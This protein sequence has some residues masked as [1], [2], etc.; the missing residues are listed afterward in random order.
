MSDD[1]EDDASDFDGDIQ[2]LVEARDIL[3]AGLT[4]TDMAKLFRVSSVTM[5]SVIGAIQPSGR[6]GTRPIY[7]VA[8]AAPLVV[9]PILDV[10]SYIRKLKPKDLPPSLQK[11]FWDAQEARQ[12]FE[13]KAGNLWH[14]YRVQEVIGKLVM[15]VR[16]RLVLATDQVD[17][18][19]PLTEEQRK[20]VQGTF[21]AITVELQKQVV[22]AF[23]DYDGAGDRQDLFENGPPKPFRPADSPDDGLDP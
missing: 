4:A 16:Q 18:L 23:K 21:D 13:E 7:A 5:K 1:I 20:I 12:S 3:F 10:E 11:A 19:A 17:R 6:R 14:T 8:D 15:I 22:D 2:T 9:K